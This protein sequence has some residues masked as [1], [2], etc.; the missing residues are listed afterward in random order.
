MEQVSPDLIKNDFTPEFI[1]GVQSPHQIGSERANLFQRLLTGY[2]C[3]L[4]LRNFLFKIFNLTKPGKVYA[5]SDPQLADHY[6][7][8][9][10][11]YISQLRKA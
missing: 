10:K 7:G 2:D 9:N 3:P 5:F 11:N 8:V 1:D 4:V 6:G